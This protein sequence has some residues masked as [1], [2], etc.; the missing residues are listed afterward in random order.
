MKAVSCGKPACSFEEL[1]QVPEHHDLE[2]P[3]LRFVVAYLYLYYNNNSNNNNNIYICIHVQGYAMH[4]VSS[5]VGQWQRTGWI[6]RHVCWWYQHSG[7]KLCS[8]FLFCLFLISLK[9]RNMQEPYMTL[10]QS[11]SYYPCRL[12]HL[13]FQGCI[14]APQ[15]A[16]RW[17]WV[18]HGQAGSVWWRIYHFEWQFSW[19]NGD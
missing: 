14:G 18:R 16:D 5:K 17:I 4:R 12:T 9:S 19:E 13:I 1:F 7:V 11:G 6:D 3:G 10:L 2:A 15:W 8:G